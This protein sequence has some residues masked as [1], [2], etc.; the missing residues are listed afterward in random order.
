MK[1][2]LFVIGSTF[3]VA[4]LALN[5]SISLSQNESSDVTISMLKKVSVAQAEDG[6]DRGSISQGEDC[7]W[8]YCVPN[9]ITGELEWYIAYGVRTTCLLSWPNLGCEEAGCHQK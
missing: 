3:L 6:D 5:T 4:A 1:R 9:P 8:S 2:A 7:Y